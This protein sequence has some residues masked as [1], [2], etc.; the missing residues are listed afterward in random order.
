MRTP[1]ILAAAVVVLAAA[2]GGSDGGSPDDV[3]PSPVSADRVE[4]GDFFYEPACVEVQQDATLG[5]DN[6][7]EAPHTFTIDG[8]EADVAAGSSQDLDLT[9]VAPGTYEV[10]CTYHPQMTGGLR[11][12]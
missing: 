7:G 12:V 3:C 8:A 11:I 5:L 9:G 1:L 2:C 4:M 10:T 6:T